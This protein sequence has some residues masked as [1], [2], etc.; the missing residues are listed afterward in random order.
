M[1]DRS[2]V[3]IALVGIG[4]Y[5]GHYLPALLT[6]PDGRDV[7]LV[8]AVDPLPDRCSRLAELQGRGV[9]IY[10]DMAS[11][12]AERAADLV[13]IASP[14]HCHCA[15]TCLALANGANVLCEKPVAPTIQEAL[16]MQEAAD[17]AGRFVA[18]GYQWSF[19]G[20]VQELKRDILDGRFGRPLRL[21]TLVL[22]P[23]AEKYYRRNDWAG[24]VRTP[25]GQWVL[26]SPVANA[27]AHYLHNHHPVM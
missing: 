4:G 22:W 7:R 13:V 9:P 5:G 18:V 11:L 1:S 15:Q 25:E 27:T 3:D 8:G 21:K 19:T 14:I 24:R 23:R 6:P 16:R 10:P 17:R 12:F 2:A 20:A 26:D